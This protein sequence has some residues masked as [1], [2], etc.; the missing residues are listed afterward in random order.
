MKPSTPFLPSLVNT[1]PPDFRCHLLT[2]DSLGKCLFLLIRRPMCVQVN[3]D[4][5]QGDRGAALITRYLRYG[6]H[7]SPRSPPCNCPM[8]RAHP[9]L[10]VPS[11]ARW[12]GTFP[13]RQHTF[14]GWPVLVSQMR[15]ISVSS[16]N[17]GRARSR[18]LD[19]YRRPLII[20][21]EVG[22]KRGLPIANVAGYTLLLVVG[23][24]ARLFLPLSFSDDELCFQVILYMTDTCPSSQPLEVLRRQGSRRLITCGERSL[25]RRP[26]SQ[27]RRKISRVPSA[28]LLGPVWTQRR[29]N[30]QR[31]SKEYQARLEKQQM[32]LKTPS[33]RTL[34]G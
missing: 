31:Q 27:R 26:T 25:D 21:R 15:P 28:R 8:Q 18:L 17:M 34:S 32:V 12:V 5:S 29:R 1:L 13:I 33:Y 7:T 2:T 20:I 9:L 14:R 24:I 22:E 16:V 4:R 23:E 11:T 10:R 30:F 6:H 19:S 3:G